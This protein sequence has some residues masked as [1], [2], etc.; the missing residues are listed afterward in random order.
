MPE[1]IEEEI[2]EEE[3]ETEEEI[4]EEVEEEIIDILKAEI[5]I[6]VTNI[7]SVG[8]F[9]DDDVVV[10][11]TIS[12]VD[13]FILEDELYGKYRFIKEREVGGQEMIKID[14][15]DVFLSKEELLESL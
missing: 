3:T 2:I 8:F 1:E 7:G 6:M 13:A 4:E 5:D 12:G 9:M 10:E 11:L 15:D 14:A